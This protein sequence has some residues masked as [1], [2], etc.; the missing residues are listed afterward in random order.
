MFMADND[1]IAAATM[2]GARFDNVTRFCSRGCRTSKSA[3]DTERSRQRG[4]CLVFSD[5]QEDQ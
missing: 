1:E 4:G 2:R 5:G 3:P